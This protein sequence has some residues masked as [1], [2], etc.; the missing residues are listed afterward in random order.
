MQKTDFSRSKEF[1][2]HKLVLPIE[3]KETCLRGFIAIHNDTLGLPAVGGTRMF[4]YDSKEQA[5]DDVLRLSRAMTYKC[6][7]AK[8]P[9]GGA[10]G[11]IIGDPKK[12]KTKQLLQVYAKKVKDLA[13]KFCTGE[14]VGIS[15]DDVIE[16]LATSDYFIGKP[17]FAADPSP[18]ASLSTFYSMQTAMEVILNTTSLKELR[19]AIKGVGKT[20]SELARLLHEQG[21][22][23]YVADIDQEALERVQQEIPGVTVVDSNT[24]HTLDIDV[25]APC[26]LGGEFSFENANQV[27]AKIICG[28]ANNQLADKKVGDWF[29]DHHVTYI[30]DYVVN[31]GGLIDVVDEL[32]K[33]GYK[34]ERVLKRIRAVQDTVAEILM[35]SARQHRSPHRVADEIAESYFLPPKHFQP[36]R[37]SLF[38]RTRV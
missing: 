28:T 22:I 20:G 27:R 19:V 3:D 38:P 7:I 32:E 36:K 24:I 31:S 6:A 29:F 1:D 17:Q 25:Y 4:P 21:V 15:Q 30:P 14:D 33:D 37:F 35:I 10:K 18:Y 13:G 16:M 34:Q 12:D 8:V 26:A 5:L 9:H 2:N 11:V 23:L